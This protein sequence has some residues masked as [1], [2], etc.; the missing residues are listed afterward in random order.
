M[1]Y[2]RNNLKVCRKKKLLHKTL[3]LP[4]LPWVHNI[5]AFVL[6]WCGDWLLPLI[7][8]PLYGVL[9]LSQTLTPWPFLIPELLTERN[10]AK[11]TLKVLV[12]I[13]SL[14]FNSFTPVRQWQ[15]LMIYLLFTPMSRS[16]RLFDL[17][18][19]KHMDS[20]I[21]HWFTWHVDLNDFWPYFELLSSAHGPDSTLLNLSSKF[22]PTFPCIS[23]ILS[24][25]IV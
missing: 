7:Y 1:F 8:V 18:V 25:T 11:F 13:H 15:R 10:E 3:P 17:K 5:S 23:S 14:N 20:L 4:P 9:P 6:I 22:C 21:C 24:G 19:N 2:F 12:S 16:H